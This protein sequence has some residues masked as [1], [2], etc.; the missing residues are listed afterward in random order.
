MNLTH[1]QR[2]RTS[3]FTLIEIILTLLLSAIL[4]I[5]LLPYL[6]TNLTKSSLPIF[7]VQGLLTMQAV[8]ENI[9]TD[10]NARKKSAQPL[11]V[12]LSELQN[13]IGRE[14]EP[15]ENSYGK[16]QVVCNHFVCFAAPTNQETACPDPKDL[17]VTVRDTLGMEFTTLFSQ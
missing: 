8:L 4:G 1:R 5:M 16:Y 7:Q 9:F 6:M 17:K 2:E 14:G 3:G 10:Y 11:P 13:A 15:Q 12:D